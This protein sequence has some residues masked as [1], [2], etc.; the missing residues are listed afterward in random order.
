MVLWSLIALLFMQCAKRGNPTGGPDDETS[1]VARADPAL[2][3]TH[4]NKE[5]S[6]VF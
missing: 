6:F 4:F 2:N 3:T 1:C 5:N